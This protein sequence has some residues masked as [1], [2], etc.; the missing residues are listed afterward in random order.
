MMPLPVMRLFKFGAD[1]SPVEHDRQRPADVRAAQVAE[2]C[3][4]RHIEREPDRPAALFVPRTGRTGQAPLAVASI[5]AL[6]IRVP[7]QDVL[8]AIGPGRDRGADAGVGVEL[9]PAEVFVGTRAWAESF[10]V[11]EAL[12]VQLIG[13]AV[14]V[15]HSAV[16]VDVERQDVELQHAAALQ[17]PLQSRG[18]GDLVAN[19]LERLRRFEVGGDRLPTLGEAAVTLFKLGEPLGTRLFFERD[20][21]L[22]I[23]D[24]QVRL[25]ERRE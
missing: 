11:V 4:A 8:L 14:V 3:S 21:R 13:Q 10:Q 24:T 6:L 19:L 20:Q 5:Q 16:V 12:L 2:E 25:I 17:E 15:T 18:V 22:D 1:D 23:L 9:E 7:P